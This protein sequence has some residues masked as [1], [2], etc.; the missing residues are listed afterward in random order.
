[1]WSL[2][3][4][5]EQTIQSFLVQQSQYDWSYPEIGYSHHATPAGYDLDHHRTLLGRG[6][7]V[8]D[9]A[10]AAINHWQMFPQPWTR[11]VPADTPIQPGNDVA[12]LFQVFGVWWLNACRIVYVLDDTAPRQRVGFAYGTLPAHVECGEERFSVE[13]D[14]EDHVWYDVRA[15]SRPRHWLT[16][17]GYPLARRLQRRFVSASQAAM[18]HVVASTTVQ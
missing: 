17:L 3:P 5:S 15:F 16:R 14:V 11:I 2:H 10:C 12:V 4:P 9:A 6:Q 13:R 7:A 1:M 18:R 8:F